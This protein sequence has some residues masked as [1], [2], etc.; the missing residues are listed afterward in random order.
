MFTAD[1]T[2][3]L[4][5]NVT[6][7]YSVSLV[8]GGY[9]ETGT[10]FYAVSKYSANQADA[11]AFLKYLITPQINAG[12]YYQAGE[13]PI[14]KAAVALI[15]AN[16]SVPQWERNLDSAVFNTAAVGWANPPNLTYTSTKLIPAFNQ[17]IY[18]FLT[19]S[20]GSATA[21]Q[22]AL[23]TAAASWASAVASGGG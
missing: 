22:Q 6:G 16:S 14:S 20:D 10:D 7:K 18:N 5:S 17:P 1:A 4:N 21:A 13:F 15:N 19:T 3:L 9:A 12:I 8:P 2:S 11:E 23:N